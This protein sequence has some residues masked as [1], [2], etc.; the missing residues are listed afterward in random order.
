MTEISLKYNDVV[1]LG[2]LQYNSWLFIDIRYVI[3]AAVLGEVLS[4]EQ[5]PRRFNWKQ[6]SLS[7][8]ILT[9]QQSVVEE[10]QN[11]DAFINCIFHYEINL[12]I[13]TIWWLLGATSVSM[14]TNEWHTFGCVF[15][16]SH[17]LRLLL[18]HSQLWCIAIVRF[19][20]QQC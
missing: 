2:K 7:N 9:Y 20:Q 18:S 10:T 16:W 15:A 13:V 1:V 5:K 6:K 19:N 4:N 12:I 11:N 14:R 8:I 3:I 17:C